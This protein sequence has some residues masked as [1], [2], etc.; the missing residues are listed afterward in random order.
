MESSKP[1]RLLD[2]LFYA[3]REQEPRK[4]RG[5]RR[6]NTSRLLV[7]LRLAQS[8]QGSIFISYSPSDSLF[9]AS[10]CFCP[11]HTNVVSSW[12]PFC[13]SPSLLSYAGQSDPPQIEREERAIDAHLKRNGDSYLVKEVIAHVEVRILLIPLHIFICCLCDQEVSFIIYR[14]Y[15]DIECEKGT[16]RYPITKRHD[17][18]M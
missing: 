5:S 14:S 9:D 7:G 3:E 16:S 6:L 15:I 13:F 1:F 10:L 18:Q 8:D 12:R 2:T 17:H 11:E 4:D